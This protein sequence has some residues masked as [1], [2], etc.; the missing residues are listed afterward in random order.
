MLSAINRERQAAGLSNVATCGA[1]NRTAQAYADVLIGTRD[2][3]HTG[4]NGSTL[5]TRVA[6]SG[7]VGWT[8]IGE[9]LAAG[10]GTVDEVMTAWLGSSGHRANILKPEFTHVG[11]GRTKGLYKD[12]TVESWFWVQNFGAGGI[13]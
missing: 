2:I 8:N 12:N 3:S 9:N 13:C 4:P 10:Q 7:Y 11:F 1:L 6:A 5:Q